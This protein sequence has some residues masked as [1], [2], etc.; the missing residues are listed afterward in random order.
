M[1]DPKRVLIVAPNWLGDIVMALP[2]VAAFRD[3][4]A[5]QHLAVALPR[6]M[7]PVIRLLSGLD[8]VVPL[9]PSVLA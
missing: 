3:H 4:F 2:S 1:T 6:G 7:V 9:E 5:L 8:A